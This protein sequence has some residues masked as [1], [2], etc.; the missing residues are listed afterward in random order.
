MVICTKCGFQ[1]VDDSSFCG[2]C[3][4]FLEWT[5]EKIQPAA[6]AQEPEPAEPEARRGGLIGQARRTLGMDGKPHDE[7]AGA[8]EGAASGANAGVPATSLPVPPAPVAPGPATPATV[9]VSSKRVSAPVEFGPADQGP[10]SQGAGST[11]PP[12]DLWEPSTQFLPRSGDAAP[13]VPVARTVEPP[14]VR[15]SPPQPPAQRPSA[16]VPPVAAVQPGAVQPG[17]VQPGAVQPV[18]VK[19]GAVQPR[20]VP[21]PAAAIEEAPQPGDVVCANCGTGNEATRRF[22]RR[23]G[24]SLAAMP[25]VHRVPWWRRLFSRRTRQ[26]APTPA[27]ARPQ[28][29]QRDAAT[30]AGGK[31]GVLLRLF[32]VIL[33]G[34]I[35]IGAAGLIFVPGARDAVSSEANQIRMAVA[36]NYVQVHTAGAAVG[37]SIAGH[38]AGQAF[39]GFGNT[40]WA[41]PASESQPWIQAGFSPKT[42]IAKVLVTSGDQADFQA[43]PRPKRI[44]LDFADDKNVILYSKEFD[45]QDVKD[46]QTLDVDATGVSALRLTVLEVYQSNSGKNVAITE[47]EFW[48][49]Q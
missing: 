30:S 32:A 46:F 8:A 14:P 20:P 34:A 48:T 17:A 44:K 47:V 42:N 22:C 5:G 12:A 31:G 9:V 18:A 3:G 45:L 28:S 26:A 40:Y 29:V 35:A 15:P 2:S 36:P 16:P 21:K 37:P 25:V 27:G 10:A 24:A 33:A 43:Q 11:P 19:P 13:D 6:P 49:R 23:C 1:N 38:E 4:S 39:D 41:A 7:V